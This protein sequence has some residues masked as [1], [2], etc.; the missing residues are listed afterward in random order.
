M[1]MIQLRSLDGRH[2]ML[3]Q[4]AGGGKSLRPRIPVQ[5]IP[6][7]R[8][9]LPESFPCPKVAAMKRG[10]ERRIGWMAAAGMLTALLVWQP[11]PLLAAA[12]SAT[13][14]KPAEAANGKQATPAI[15]GNLEHGKQIFAN[16]CSHCHR[17]DHQT[18]PVGAP[19]LLDVLQRH[20]AEWIFQWVHS[21]AAFAKTDKAAKALVEGNPYGLVMPTFPEMQDPQNRRDVIEYLKT[22][23]SK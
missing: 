3:T 9:H 6:G 16:I 19:G 10:S 8:Q 12:K 1:V 11:S 5:G 4:G 7:I 22:L 2:G 17:I 15:T 13:A 20:T 23:K 18:S 21:P 14:A